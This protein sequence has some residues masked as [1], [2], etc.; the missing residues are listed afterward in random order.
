LSHDNYAI[1]SDFDSKESF[2]EMVEHLEKSEL[3]SKTLE[4]V[5]ENI[6]FIKAGTGSGKTHSILEAIHSGIIDVNNESKAVISTPTR[7]MAMDIQSTGNVRVSNEET[8]D[9]VG[10]WIGGKDGK[11]I[12]KSDKA[13]AVGLDDERPNA[14]WIHAR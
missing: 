9:F 11:Q 4:P 12:E 2:M 3:I 5:A 1:E 7:A 8:G 10:L 13:V 14:R 6:F